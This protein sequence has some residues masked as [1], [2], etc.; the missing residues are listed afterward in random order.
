MDLDLTAKVAVVTGARNG[1]GLAITQALT[2][3][4]RPRRRR[5]P[6]HLE[7]C[8]GLNGSSA[9]AV[10]LLTPGGPASW[11]SGRS[12]STAASTCW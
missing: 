6:H 5:L 4:G 9:V 12:T 2:D 3:E 1:I 11:S 7:A 10:D 8:D